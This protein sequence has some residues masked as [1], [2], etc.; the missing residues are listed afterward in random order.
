MEW[1]EITVHTDTK[2]VDPVGALLMDFGIDSFITEDR[3]DFAAFLNDTSVYWDYI[4]EDL[5]REKSSGES[6]LK[7][8]LDDVP[9]TKET[10][11]AL[12]EALR[13]LGSRDKN[14]EYGTLSLTA[15]LVRKEDWENNWKEFFKPFPVG[16]RFLIKPSWEEVGDTQGRIVLEI[17]PAS[18]FGTGSHETTQLCIC[19]LEQHVRGGEKMLD[20]GTGSGILSI[21]AHLLGAADITAV[22]VDEHCL[23]TAA[24]NC[25]KNGFSL[26]VFCGDVVADT[27]LCQAVGTG[28]DLICANIVADVIVNM[29]EILQEKLKK[30]GVLIASGILC[31]RA[32]D[33][34]KA[35]ETA[36]FVLLEERSSGD[37]ISVTAT[38]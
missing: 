20:M 35:L 26:Q 34:K 18:S 16:K 30:G 33:V 3:L 7:F 29:A 4:D 8:Y 21:A 38:R 15:E 5:V 37:W 31:T 27:R 10:I 32:E 23:K 36:G 1:Y 9:E 22:D 14:G 25:E 17:D 6:R 24:E 28:Y 19:A 13:D 2:G 12:E 11:R